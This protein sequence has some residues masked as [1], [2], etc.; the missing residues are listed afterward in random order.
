[1]VS[2]SG[3]RHAARSVTAMRFG[4]YANGFRFNSH[5]ANFP[6]VFFFIFFRLKVLCLGVSV[7]LG[8]RLRLRLGLGFIFYI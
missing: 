5:L 2:L 7:R 4:C 1:M 8:L 3:K 6:L